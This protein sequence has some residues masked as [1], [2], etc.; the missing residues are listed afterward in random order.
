MRVIAGTARHMVLKT[1]PGNNTRPTQDKI[2]ET[3][4][5]I[6]QND[7]YDVRFLD[8]FAGSGGIGIEALSRGAQYAVFVDGDRWCAKCIAENLATTK[9][10]EQAEV[11]CRDYKAALRV[12]EKESPFDIIFVDP[13]YH[14]GYYRDVLTYFLEASYVTEDTLIILEADI[15]EDLS[16]AEEL[17][18]EI[19]R[20][21]EYKSNMHL[22][23]RR[24]TS[25]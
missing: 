11:I 15:H 7:I 24:S 21:K 5:N 4:F 16:F 25:L 1:V 9:F 23:I 8:L 2:K 14:N 17:G 10:T 20:R 6:L 3:L 13:P 12:L 22:F 18:Y 19:L